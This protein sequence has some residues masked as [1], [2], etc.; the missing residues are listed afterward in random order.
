MRGT[1]EFRPCQDQTDRETSGDQ[2]CDSEGHARNALASFSHF[3]TT[4]SS[5]FLPS[6]IADSIDSFSLPAYSFS[7]I[8]VAAPDCGA[9]NN[10]TPAPMKAPARNSATPVPMVLFA[11]CSVI[12]ITSINF[13]DVV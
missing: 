1:D 12:A 6:S 10:A 5:V 7:C 2:E 9:S 11:L 4:V 3:A 13:S 8:R